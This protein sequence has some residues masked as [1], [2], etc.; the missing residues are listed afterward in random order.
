[1]STPNASE[2]VVYVNGE[3]LPE[4]QARVSPLDRGFLY[5]DAIFETIRVSNGHCFLWESHMARLQAG[6]AYLRIATNFMPLEL[7]NVSKTVLTANRVRDGFLRIELSRGVGVRGYSPRGADGRT[8][9]ISAHEGPKF[10][11]ARLSVITASVRVMA[12]EPWTQLKTANRL[13]NILA[14]REA[15]EAEA[16]EALLLN[17]RWTVSGASGANVFCLR[18]DLLLTPPLAA[19]GIAGTT[20]SFVMRAAARLG[21]HAA[22][23]ELKLEDLYA[24][25]AVF[26][27]S[28]GLLVS[29]VEKI[30]SKPM[31]PSNWAVEALRRLCEDALEKE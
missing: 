28:A 26:L 29:V 7:A 18:R 23:E 21:L 12:D 14:K 24:A 10:S 30:E 2:P 25:D 5:G 6:A 15:D 1:V 8:L 20:R 19:G 13:P 11:A 9:V 22:Q 3:F 17:H 4:K 27:T 16:D 31:D